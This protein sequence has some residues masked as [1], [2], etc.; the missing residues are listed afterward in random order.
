MPYFRSVH[1]A[2][3]PPLNSPANHT[4]PHTHIT[5]NHTVCGCC[6][7]APPSWHAILARR[8]RRRPVRSRLRRDSDD[9]DDDDD[10]KDETSRCRPLRRRTRNQVLQASSQVCRRADALAWISSHVHLSAIDW[11]KDAEH[12]GRS[13][14]LSSGAYCA[15]RESVTICVSAGCPE[16]PL[17]LRA[18]CVCAVCAVSVWAVCVCVD[19]VCR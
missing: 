11:T 12:A 17:E 16:Q 8:R 2:P 5:T 1:V 7:V 18:E 19:H 4:S 15:P 14:D 9:G 6:G 3:P 10:D 13:L